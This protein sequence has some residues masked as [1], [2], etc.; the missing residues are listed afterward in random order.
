MIAL[1]FIS[2]SILV[3]VEPKRFQVGTESTFTV[4]R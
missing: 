4:W 1:R 2:Q 3:L